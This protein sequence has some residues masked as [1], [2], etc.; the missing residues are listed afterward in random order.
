MGFISFEAFFSAWHRS[1]ICPSGKFLR[2]CPQGQF[3]VLY[4]VGERWVPLEQM[5]VSSSPPLA[6]NRPCLRTP[7]LQLFW[8]PADVDAE[9]DTEWTVLASLLVSNSLFWIS[10][11]GMPLVDGWSG[12]GIGLGLVGLILVWRSYWHC[13]TVTLIFMGGLSPNSSISSLLGI[14]SLYMTAPKVAMSCF[15]SNGSSWLPADGSSSAWPM[16][17][18]L[19]NAAVH[20]LFLMISDRSW[21]LLAVES[22][23]DMCWAKLQLEM[24]E[25]TTAGSFWKLVTADFL[26]H[27][28]DILPFNSG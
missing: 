28:P 24:D 5:I 10:G 18:V 16:I 4:N 17:V 1:W 14:Q 27:F 23:W 25:V 13:F 2:I 19:M 3:P 11:F 26:I 15:I 6:G 12:S 20:P 8:T 21:N 9:L 22:E 7:T